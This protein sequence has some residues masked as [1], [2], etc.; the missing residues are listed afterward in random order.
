MESTETAHEH[1]GG[2]AMAGDEAAHEE[3]HAH[4]RYMLVWLWLALLTVAEVAIVWFA[5]LPRVWIVVMLLFMAVWKALLVA[6][7]FMHLR[8]EPKRVAL[9]AASPLPLAVLLIMAV[10]MEYR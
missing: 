10:M 9:L 5:F 4:P 8:F 1:P 7:Y 6:L 2:Q 3:S